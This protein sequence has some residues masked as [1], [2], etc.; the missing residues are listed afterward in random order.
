MLRCIIY[1]FEQAN[2]NVLIKSCY[3]LRKGFIKYNKCNGVTPMK[4]HIDC[5][6]PKL[7]TTRKKQLTKVIPLDHTQQPTK[8]RVKVT[9]N[10]ITNFFGFSNPYKQHDEQQQKFF[11]DLVLYICEGYKVLATCENI[12]LKRLVLC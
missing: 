9:S 8:K 6:H 3:I 10:V 5:V 12:W 2:D 11:E 7:L 4:T 1:R